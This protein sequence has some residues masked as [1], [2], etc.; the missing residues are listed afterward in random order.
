MTVDDHIIKVFGSMENY[1]NARLEGELAD[2]ESAELE[3]I[4]RNVPK[5]SKTM[6]D[7]YLNKFTP[8]ERDVHDH[9]MLY[10]DHENPHEDVAQALGIKVESVKRYQRNIQ[11]YLEKDFEKI[12]DEING[13]GRETR[14][15]AKMALDIIEKEEV[16][17]LTSMYPPKESKS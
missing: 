11:R 17:F 4:R 7:I 8:R 14:K 1:I 16:S 6:G 13:T 9:L 12:A 3:S 5:L 2:Q 15:K 10:S